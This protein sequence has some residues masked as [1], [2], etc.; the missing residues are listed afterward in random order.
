[1][2][3]KFKFFSLSFDKHEQN[4]YRKKKK[5]E[6]KKWKIRLRI[7]LKNYFAI[8]YKN[9]LWQ[10]KRIIM[11]MLS[12]SRGAREKEKSSR[13]KNFSRGKNR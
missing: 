10:I 12:F 5:N 4:R 11:R 6:G 8:K 7:F 1:M 3:L 9:G 13:K 2:Y